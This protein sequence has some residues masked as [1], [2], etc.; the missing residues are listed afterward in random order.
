M[1]NRKPVARWR[2]R[3]GRYWITLYKCEEGYSYSSD[4]GGGNLGN[5]SYEDAVAAIEKQVKGLS[6]VDGIHLKRSDDH[7]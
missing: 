6:E 7:E 3:G 2:T 1:N 5:L 4:N